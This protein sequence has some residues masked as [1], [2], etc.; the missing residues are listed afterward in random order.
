MH[1]VS[2]GL[3]TAGPNNSATDERTLA[4]LQFYDTVI[5]RG[6]QREQRAAGDDDDRL[7]RIALEFG[8]P[9]SVRTPG[10]WRAGCR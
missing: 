5:D 9:C 8:E 6:R 1:R 3:S 7:A 4:P 10:E 2:T